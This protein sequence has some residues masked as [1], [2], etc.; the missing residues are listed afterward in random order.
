MGKKDTGDEILL[1]LLFAG[2]W[3]DKNIGHEIINMFRADDGDNYIYVN[4]YGTF[5]KSHSG[6]IKKILL[7]RYLKGRNMVKIIAKDDDLEEL[8]DVSSPT[9]ESQL[10]SC[11]NITYGGTPTETAICFL[12]SRSLLNNMTPLSLSA[13]SGFFDLGVA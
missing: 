8:V 2:E 6:K 13:S 3:L 11:E 12:N 9:R 5:Q 1:I 7:G 10:K 4:P